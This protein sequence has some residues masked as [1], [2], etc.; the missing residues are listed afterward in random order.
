MTI[1]LKGA[2]IYF[3]AIHA[4]ISEC[5]FINNNATD[6]MGGDFYYFSSD[7]QTSNTD[8]TPLIENCEFISIKSLGVNMIS[9]L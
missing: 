5:T 6:D 4:T 9:S 1:K 8:E 7:I 2:A 3:I